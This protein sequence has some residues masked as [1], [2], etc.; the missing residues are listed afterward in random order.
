MKKLSIIAVFITLLATPVLAL[1][2][3]GLFTDQTK[4]SSADFES[5]PIEQSNGVY[6]WFNTSLFENSSWMLNSEIMYKYNFGY[7]GK[8]EKTAENII[9]FTNIF[10]LDLLKISGS[11]PLTNGNMAVMMG[12]YFIMD[13]SGIVFDQTCDG[14]LVKYSAPTYVF[15][16]YIGY[17]GLLNAFNVTILEPKRSDTGETLYFVIP[18]DADIYTFAHPYLPIMAT[19]EFPNVF[20]NQTLSLQLCSF[21]DLYKG[22]EEGDYV[23]SNRIYGSI[24]LKGPLGGPVFYSLVSVIGSN[25]FKTLNNYS[26]IMISCYP[27][28][29]LSFKIG[30][31]YASGKQGILQTFTGFSSNT[32]YH[33][34]SSPEYGDVILPQISFVASNKK[35]YSNVTA[36]VVLAIPETQITFSGVEGAVSAV[37]NVF[38]DFQL[39]ADVTTY[40]NIVKE[41]DNTESYYSITAGA[42]ISF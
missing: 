20:K 40:F 28:G 1:E 2:W 30:A 31:E 32:A 5:F 34:L 42:K 26:K 14:V 22:T 11:I 18:E 37:Y 35:F 12:R 24:L 8:D 39:L 4:V 29:L 41:S 16:G 10:D 3:G 27:T 38:S 13:N 17:T 23:P 15:S 21:L 7:F 33:S 9:S 19:L 6:L 36:K 25:D